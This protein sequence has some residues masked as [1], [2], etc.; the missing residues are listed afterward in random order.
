M[1]RTLTHDDGLAAVYGG[2]ILGGGGGGHLAD[3]LARVESI[4]NGEYAD[5]ELVSVEELA[6]D[7]VVACVAM[8][9][10]P[11]A[12]SAFISDEQYIST[13][14]LLKQAIGGELA[15]V[16]T[17]EN[18][19]ATTINGWLQA[20]ALGLPV[21]DAPANG[22]AHPTGVMGALQLHQ[23]PD[24]VS[25]QAFAGGRGREKLA[26]VL[27]GP[28]DGV[29]GAIRALSVRGGGMIGV[30][31]N[32]VP[33]SRA[34]AYGAVGGISFAIDLGTAFLRGSTGAERIANAVEFL[35][36]DIIAH[37]TVKEIDL[38]RDGGFDVG[39]VAIGGPR[40]LELSFWNEY[41]SAEM[42]GE[43]LAT[44]PD[45]IMTMDSESGDPILS[46]KIRPGQR[47]TVIVASKS[48]LVLG[49]SMFDREQL[50]GIEPILGL[51]ILEHQ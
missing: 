7:D 3:G 25:Y 29:A 1:S 48:R 12:E 49:A 50:A 10:A 15:A 17:N 11:S 32:Q 34:A 46:A 31:R 35:G 40:R 19:P 36:G 8:V 44:F 33:V 20:A 5:P 28:L 30:C 9:G 37:G 21:L 14:H 4:F 16:M 27:N 22:R 26:G 47:V 24:Y 51:P 41:M 38:R 42:D 13:V 39:R 2:G 23:E 18:G 45:L 43:R 6:P